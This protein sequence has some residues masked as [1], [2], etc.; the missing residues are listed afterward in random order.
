MMYG[1]GEAAHWFHELGIKRKGLQ[2]IAVIDRRAKSLGRY[3]GIP[4][5][6]LH[7]ASS[8]PQAK[9]CI[10]V[11]CVGD[12]LIFQQVRE[13]LISAGFGEVHYQGAF[14]E[15][16][17]LLERDFPWCADW[18]SEFSKREQDIVQSFSLFSD[19]QSKDLYAQLIHAHYFRQP[20]VFPRRP[21]KEQYF[22]EDVSLSRG[23]RSVVVCGAYD[24]EIVDAFS[25]HG[26]RPQQLLLLEP[27]SHIYRRLT[28]RLS[29]VSRTVA[30]QVFAIPVAVSDKSGM[31]G[32]L[33]GDGL[34]SRICAEGDGEV[35]AVTLDD[36]LPLADVT[37]ITMDIEGQEGAA[38][39]GASR[40]IRS[41]SPDLAVC[42]Y[43]YP[44]QLW[45]IPLLIRAI[46]PTYRFFLRN[47]T[48]YAIETVLYASKEAH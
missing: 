48:S 37:L 26:L 7:E 29:A 23:Y 12:Y 33:S 5:M 46:D 16:H 35:Q 41:S 22:P 24:G 25:Y 31:T 9:Q 34:G 4:C 10:V 18:Q 27:E 38:L 8:H 15:M 42:V 11:V 3:H 45:E 28:A 17:H 47:Y 1:A 6:P 32:F 40:M 20:M 44:A 19:E 13:E 36:L 21:R 2:P 30:D 43:H 39:R 14:Y